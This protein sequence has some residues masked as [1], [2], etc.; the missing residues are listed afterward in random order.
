MEELLN[1]VL[2]EKAKT[3]PP[4]KSKIDWE[5]FERT[6]RF[7]VDLIYRMQEW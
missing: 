5:T 7:H 3:L 4:M 1:R 6:F 2:S